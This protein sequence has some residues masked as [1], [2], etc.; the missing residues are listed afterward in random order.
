MPQAFLKTLQARGTLSPEE[1]RTIVD[2]TRDQVGMEP[3]QDIVAQG[4]RP[5]FSCLM[6][7]GYSVRY[8]LLSSGARQITAIHVPGDFVDLHSLFLSPMDHGVMAITPARIACVSHASLNEMIETRPNLT[9]LF[10]T[11]TMIDAAI[12]RQWLVGS[13]RQN[14][15]SQIARFLCET[16]VRLAL[17]DMVEG[18]SF[19]LP[20]TQGLLG[21]AMGISIVQANRS[22]Q[23]LRKAGLVQWKGTRVSILDWPGLVALGEFDATYLNVRP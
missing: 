21:D 19:E 17:V 14:A 6:I 18:V 5:T 9:R 22:I 12:H 23:A 11:M 1:A 8:A 16:F 4:S 20:V 3:G 7:A 15:D 13:G 2:L 10:W